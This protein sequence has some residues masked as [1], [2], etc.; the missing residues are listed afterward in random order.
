MGRFTIGTLESVLKSDWV[1]LFPMARSLGFD[2]VELTTTSEPS[3]G[4]T[5][6][7]KH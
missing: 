2:C 3:F 1:D 4:A 5:K 7:W 6:D